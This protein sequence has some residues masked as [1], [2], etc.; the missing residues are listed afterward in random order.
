MYLLL[1]PLPLGHING[2]N[3]DAVPFA[4]VITVEN[5]SRL[6]F[7]CRNCSCDNILC[8]S[9]GNK[10][11]FPLVNTTPHSYCVTKKT[12][13]PDDVACI[14]EFTMTVTENSTVYCKQ[15]ATAT[16]SCYAH[17]LCVR[18]VSANYILVII[19]DKTI[20]TCTCKRVKLFNNDSV[21]L[22]VT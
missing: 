3:G 2:T 14:N 20:E 16:D 9:V 22:H 21:Y 13:D 7:Y 15:Q 11:I 17:P 10:H 1:L 5:G 18:N 4:D 6:T 8:W 19:K 12:Y